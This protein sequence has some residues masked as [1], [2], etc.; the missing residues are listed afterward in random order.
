M[1]LRFFSILCLIIT[2]SGVVYA[3]YKVIMSGQELGYKIDLPE[4]PTIKGCF[5][6][7]SSPRQYW[8]YDESEDSHA[9]SYSCSSSFG[10]IYNENIMTLYYDNKIIHQAEKRTDDGPSRENWTN[11]FSSV[12]YDGYNYRIYKGDLKYTGSSG[13]DVIKRWEICFDA[14]L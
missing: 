5:Y 2:F 1:F 9:C 7:E 10:G 11:E 13:G 8:H 12:D 4:P 6:S 3:D 14:N